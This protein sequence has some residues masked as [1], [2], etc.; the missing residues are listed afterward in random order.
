M[1]ICDLSVTDANIPITQELMKSVRLSRSRYSQA[2]E[3]QK[4]VKNATTNEFKQKIIA[5]EIGDIVKKKRYLHLSID[6]IVKDADALADM[7]EVEG[8]MTVL[9]RSNDLRKLSKTK[10]SELSDMIA[11]LE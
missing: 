3:E 8:D 9:G 6:E 5:E 11:S 10:K 1:I 7:A 2:L 4:T